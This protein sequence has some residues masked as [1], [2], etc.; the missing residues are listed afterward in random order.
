MTF[1][2]GIKSP[3]LCDGTHP[4]LAR[5]PSDQ[6]IG[7]DGEQV[8][9]SPVALVRF[10]RPGGGGATATPCHINY[11]L[12][13]VV[14]QQLFADR[15]VS[16]FEIVAAVCDRRAGAQRAPLQQTETLPRIGTF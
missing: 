10:P 5:G 15:A 14:L 7:A 8:G 2:F 4:A 13:I 3:A 6:A 12:G 11:L 16:Q 1:R 9:V